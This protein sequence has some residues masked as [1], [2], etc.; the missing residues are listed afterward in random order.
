MDGLHA[1]AEE[2]SIELHRLVADRLRADSLLVAR[3]RERVRVWVRE[4]RVSRPLAEAWLGVLERPL[5]EIA[6]LLVDRGEDARRLRQTSPFAGV[7]DPRA[8]WAVWR[9]VRERLVRR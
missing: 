7:I 1:L 8:R 9:S 4:R 6:A 3:A 5:Q 2:R